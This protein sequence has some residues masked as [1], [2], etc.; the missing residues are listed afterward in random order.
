MY[1]IT[2][3]EPEPEINQIKKIE[4]D[5]NIILIDTENDD[6][7]ELYGIEKDLTTL[8][9]GNRIHKI[10]LKDVIPDH[11]LL[12]KPKFH[13]IIRFKNNQQLNTNQFLINQNQEGYFIRVPTI[14]EQI[15]H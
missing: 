14:T 11:I 13:L 3:L 12:S 10:L 2:D 6:L 15:I 1:N 7:F 9:Q 4:N 5:N 8:E